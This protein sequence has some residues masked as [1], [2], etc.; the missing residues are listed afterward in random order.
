[1]ILLLQGV[2]DRYKALVRP[3]VTQQTR[4]DPR[5]NITGLSKS[6]YARYREQADHFFMIG[7][8]FALRSTPCA[9]NVT[10]LSGQGVSS[11]TGAMHVWNKDAGIVIDELGDILDTASARFCRNHPHTQ[12]FISCTFEPMSNAVVR[13]SSPPPRHY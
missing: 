13:G 11:V 1:M 9:G 6:V 5:T 12:S 3:G 8:I 7:Y 4:I 2:P 10:V